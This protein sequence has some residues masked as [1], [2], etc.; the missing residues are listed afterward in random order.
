MSI[1]TVTLDLDGT[2]LPDTTAF[3][4]ILS[5]YG[6]ADA[7]AESDARFFAGE[8]SLRECFLEQWALFQSLTPADI[9]RALR[10]AP[11]LS[12]IRE[13]IARMRDAG[14]H[15]RMLTDQPSTVTDFGGRWG[16]EPAISSPVTVKEGEQVSIDF[17]E[18]KL[19]NLIA[20]GLEPETV[21]HVGNGGNDVPIWNAGA[22]G[23]AVFA[24]EAVA[25]QAT[26]NLGR[27]GSLLEVADAVLELARP[28]N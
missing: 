10:D 8:I 22:L 11:W 13:G 7:V 16:L 17:C 19:E 14:L 6:H 18:D 28:A 27:P 9:H 1:S 20:A 26:R 2:L 12:D 15:V 21:L 23:V 25:A 24:D 5:K 3:A 4:A